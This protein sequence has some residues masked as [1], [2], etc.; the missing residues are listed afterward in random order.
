MLM[1]LLL[2][3]IYA[4][5]N[6]WSGGPGVQGPVAA[7]GN[8]FWQS[9]NVNYSNPGILSLVTILWMF[10]SW[11]A[12]SIDTGG[13]H[14]YQGFTP[15]DIDGDGDKDLILLSGEIVRWYEFVA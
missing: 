7:W 3:Q 12:H 1:V 6:D 11:T 2:S 15:F 4:F 10:T 8:R 5:Q 9:Q 14:H 13:K